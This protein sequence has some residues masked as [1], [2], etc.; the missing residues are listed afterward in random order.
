MGK[1]KNQIQIELSEISEAQDLLR[2]QMNK[3][4]L[5]IIELKD[6]IDIITAELKQFQ[7]SA[8]RASGQVDTYKNLIR[9]RKTATMQ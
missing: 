5:K 4:R 7:A 6:K 9:N 8:K 2:D 1:T 3:D